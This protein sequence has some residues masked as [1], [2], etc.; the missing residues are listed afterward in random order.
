MVAAR[1]RIFHVCRSA[2]VGTQRNCRSDQPH[3][4]TR[5]E[6]RRR[7]RW[8]RRSRSVVA[9]GHQSRSRTVQ[10]DTHGR[11]GIRSRFTH[12]ARHRS[13][14]R[15]RAGFLWSD[16]LAHSARDARERPELANL[17]RRRFACGSSGGKRAPMLIDWR[18]E[19]ARSR[20]EEL[21]AEAALNRLARTGI[22]GQGTSA[23]RFLSRAFLALGFFFVEIGR[24]IGRSRTAF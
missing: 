18:F 16:D 19:I 5:A 4:S 21:R 12:D 7:H 8:P 1:A 2:S 20:G 10:S 3:V 23:R 22:R 6:T 14:G 13:R 15:G 24:G 17:R 9:S 11:I